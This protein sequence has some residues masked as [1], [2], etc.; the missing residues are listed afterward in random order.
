MMDILDFYV[1][2]NP[3]ETDLG[4]CRFLTVK[5]YPKF[6]SDLQLLSMSKNEIIYNMYKADKQGVNSEFLSKL[7]KLSLFDVVLTIPDLLNAY[8]NLFVEVFKNKEILHLINEKNFT[9]YRN[10]I[11]KMNAQKEEYINPNPEIQYHLDRS[12]RVKSQAGEYT[13]FGDIVIAVAIGAKVDFRQLN[14]W[15]I[16]Q[17]YMAYHS[18]GN[19][20]NYETSTLFATVDPKAKIESWAKHIDL[21]KVDDHSITMEEFKQTAKIIEN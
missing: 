11:M 7:E 19:Y 13:T 10:L 15:T 2:G 21:F 16:Y 12:K 17:L 8:S 3:I 6:L 5:E 9:Y 20:K 1:L 14:N 4:E 18:I